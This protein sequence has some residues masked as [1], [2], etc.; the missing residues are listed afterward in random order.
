MFVKQ[1]E[2]DGFSINGPRKVFFFINVGVPNQESQNWF[3]LDSLALVCRL[4][5]VESKKG[6]GD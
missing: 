1:L 3:P 4:F 6:P 2:K 5:L